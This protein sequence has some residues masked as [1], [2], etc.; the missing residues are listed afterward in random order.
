MLGLQILEYKDALTEP[1]KKPGHWTV[2]Y[3]EPSMA[4][5]VRVQRIMYLGDEY[6]IIPITSD[7]YPGIA[8]RDADANDATK[9]KILRFLSVLSWL[10]RSGAVLVSFGGGSSPFAFQRGKGH[11][12]TIR[13]EI[14]LRYL[15]EV[16]DVKARLA[17]GLMRDGRGLS[18]VA[19]SF[20]SFYR[21]LEVAVGRGQA[22]PNWITQAVTRLP[23]GR[24]KDALTNLTA[25]GVSNIPQHLYV[26]GRCAIAHAGGSPIVDPDNPSDTNRLYKEKPLI[27]ELAELAIE[28]FLGVKT[29]S[30]VYREHLYE[31]AGFKRIFG[32]IL[33]DDLLAGKAIPSGTNIDVPAISFQLHG[34]GPFEAFENLNPVHIVQEGSKV[35]MEFER[36][37]GRLRVKFNLDFENE[38]LEFDV[39]NGVFGAPDD[40]SSIYARHKAETLEFLAGYYGNGQLRISNYETGELIA[41]K[42][43][44][45]PVNVMPDYS[46]FDKDV[47]FW[48]KIE[49]NRKELEDR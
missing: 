7:A 43:E 24:G 26:S 49:N 17:L 31:L 10:D 35:R 6:W 9:E 42:D 48:R 47:E 14:D 30:T 12:F 19:Y 5:P 45:I 40:N 8:V 25:S 11:G 37:D 18:H 27:E 44:F 36:E 39:H 41:R 20:L 16:T 13:E 38:R 1:L 46:E 28:E 3:I 21:V 32:Q 2:A 15:P 22:I 29:A 34:K 4:W 33:V 23:N